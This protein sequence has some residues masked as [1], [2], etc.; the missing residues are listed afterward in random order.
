MGKRQD[1][2]RAKAQRKQNRRIAAQEARTAAAALATDTQAPEV[3]DAALE[4][5]GRL[6]K[7]P[8]E[9]LAWA[10]RKPNRHQAGD[11]FTV[12][13]P[14]PSVLPRGKDR[15]QAQM[16]FDSA[17]QDISVW[18]AGTY[19]SGWFD[20]PTFMG[21][22]AL[23]LLALLPEYRRMA[24]VLATECTRTWV[25]VTCKDATQKAKLDR[26]TALE[27]ELEK[28]D[29]RGAM[30]RL[31]EIDAFFGRSHL[32]VDD[33]TDPDNRAE[34]TTSIGNGR[35]DIT[36]AKFKGNTGFLRGFKPIEP[37]WCYPARYNATNPLKDDWYAP[38]TWYCQAQEINATRLLRF[39]GREVPDLLKPSYMFGGVS[40]SQLM[41]PYVDRWIAV[42]QAVADVLVSFSTSG[43][44]SNLNTLNQPGGDKLFERIELFNDL[45]NNRGM[46][47]VD[48][49]TEEFFQFNTPLSE[50]E[51]LVSKYQEFL[52]SMSGEPV[53]KLL[54]IQPAGLNASSQGELTSWWDWCE[55]FRL[56]FCAPHLTTIL[57]FCQINLW[58]EVDPDISWE[59]ESLR[60]LD[61]KEETEQ[62]KVQAETDATYIDA[63]VFAAEEI[64]QGLLRDPESPYFGMEEVGAD[65]PE[66]PLGAGVVDPAMAEAF[67]ELDA[68]TPAETRR[69]GVR[70]P[71]DPGE[72]VGP[73]ARSQ[74]ATA[75]PDRLERSSSAM[76]QRT[77]EPE[78]TE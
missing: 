44:K 76:R 25:K 52:C 7:I 56:S 46:M 50:L 59:F 29:V 53:V 22:P 33:G 35:D 8:P 24:E 13:K 9:V 12:P 39:V 18:A 42:V 19:A 51:A 55:A 73:D 40:L 65:L 34:L 11:L 77:R 28:F 3:K 26:V 78:P 4:A 48:K 20:G 15:S 43:L 10:K 45:R 17:Q 66:G 69:D 21:Y 16:A 60:S 62:R 1:R 32:F 74:R 70:P 54:G 64:R 31:I 27:A 57:D 2:K 36:K 67:P 47:L 75:S 68:P 58:G 41:R 30:R 38:Q 14:L 5:A 37:V 61:P 72:R 23:A 71:R 6:L 63:G 49:D